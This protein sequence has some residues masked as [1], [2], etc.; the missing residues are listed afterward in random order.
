MSLESS[1]RAE[2]ASTN[3]ETF[4]FSGKLDEIILVASL[5]NSYMSNGH[6]N[7]SKPLLNFTIYN[8]NCPT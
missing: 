1:L 4:Y 6:H 8:P 5:W 3:Q 7:E 2:W